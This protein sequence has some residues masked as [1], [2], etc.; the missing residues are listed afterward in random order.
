MSGNERE[1]RR[2]ENDQ[3]AGTKDTIACMNNRKR[4]RPQRREREWAWMS[5]R[6]NGGNDRRTTFSEGGCRCNTSGG[7]SNNRQ[8][9][10][11]WQPQQ[12]HVSSYGRNTGSGNSSGGNGSSNGTHSSSSSGSRGAYYVA[13]FPLPP[14]FFFIF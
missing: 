7:H 10:Q 13:P 11:H 2:N 12:Q 5:T 3:V 8:P 6:V 4:V 1:Q 9:H 14:V